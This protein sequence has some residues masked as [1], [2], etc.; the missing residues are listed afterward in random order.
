MNCS[1]V[2]AYPQNVSIDAATMTT[3]RTNAFK[4][5]FY[6]DR[7][8]GADFFVYNMDTNEL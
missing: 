2:N 3:R 8:I 1:I 5:T 6:G 7:T 4:F